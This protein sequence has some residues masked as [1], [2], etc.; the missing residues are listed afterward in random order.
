LAVDAAN[1]KPIYLDALYAGEDPFADHGGKIT[2][3]E[4]AMP[5]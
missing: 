2:P 1:K 3:I 4:N 5:F